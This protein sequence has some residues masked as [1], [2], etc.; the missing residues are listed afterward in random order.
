MKQFYFQPVN[1]RTWNGFHIYAVDGST[2]QIPESKENY[3]VFGGNPNKT[4][5]ISPLASASV[6]YDVINDILIDVSLHPYRYNERESA[7]AHVDFYLG[8]QTVSYFLTEDILPKTC[9]T[10]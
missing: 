3:E 6:L 9:F 2:I 7:K 1:L 8:F 5:I 4:K 10:I